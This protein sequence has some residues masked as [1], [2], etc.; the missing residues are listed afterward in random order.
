MKLTVGVV[1]TS[2]ASWRVQIAEAMNADDHRAVL[3]HLDAALI[4]VEEI[5]RQRL[6]PDDEI[7]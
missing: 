1:L 7:D 4:Q 2:I 3:R 5:M 6:N